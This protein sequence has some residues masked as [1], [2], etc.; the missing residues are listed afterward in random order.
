MF[1]I[2]L[3]QELIQTSEPA[4]GGT[5][6]AAATRRGPD[7]AVLLGPDPGHRAGQGHLRH[8]PASGPAWKALE[9]REPW[10]VWGGQLF[11]NGKVLAQK[12]RGAGPQEPPPRGRHPVDGVAGRPDSPRRNSLISNSRSQAMS[13]RRVAG[14]EAQAAR[15]PTPVRPGGPTRSAGSATGQRVSAGPAG[16]SVAGAVGAPLPVP[17]TRVVVAVLRSRRPDGLAGRHGAGPSEHN[18]P[19]ASPDQ[20]DHDR[21][22]ILVSACLLGV[23]CNHRGQASPNKEVM[24]LE[25][26]ARL[27]AVCPEVVGG[28]PTPRPAAERSPRWSGPHRRGSRCDRRSTSGV[29][30]TRSRWRAPWA[31]AGPS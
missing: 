2:E 22:V 25:A 28:L 16:A 17:G 13:V 12:R 4:D 11:L 29:P 27:V 19:V 18:G 7:G 6:P 30:P 31:P 5:T 15:Q 20:P 14:V 23:A 26:S 24:A 8:L 9:R 10:G 1:A 3:R 21:P